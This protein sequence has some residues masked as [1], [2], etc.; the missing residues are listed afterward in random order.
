MADMVGSCRCY[1]R[2]PDPTPFTDNVFNVSAMWILVQTQCLGNC[3]GSKFI[4]LM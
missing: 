1:Q 4:I 3:G 2:V